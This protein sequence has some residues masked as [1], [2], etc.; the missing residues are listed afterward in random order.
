M[1]TCFEAH[2]E[3][4]LGPA[5]LAASGDRLVGLWFRGQKYEPPLERPGSACPPETVTVLAAATQ[6]LDA[7]FAG[8]PAP[9]QPAVGPSG[10]DFQRQVWNGLQ[11]LAPGTT[12]TYGALAAAIGKPASTRAAA[13]AVGRNPIS[14]LVPCHR[15]IGADGQ[16][17]GFAGGLGR[18]RALL[19]LE[20]G[21]P[22]P[23]RRLRQDLVPQYPDPID[24]E[25][26]EQV[27]FI[28][29]PDDGEFAGWKWAVARDGRGGWVPRDWFGPGDRGARALRSYSAREL[30]G[31]AGDEILE[32]NEFSGWLWVIDRAGNCGWIP[33]AAV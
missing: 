2:V 15:V 23:W 14:I 5:R 11:R 6:W 28:D 10:T 8:R 16:L 18:K 1:N 13:A 9:S 21:R 24:V 19:A 29:R 33:T 26:G 22:L 32:L 30:P 27:D 12:T 4:Q 25:V 17:T 7:Y 20:S 31:I 3:T